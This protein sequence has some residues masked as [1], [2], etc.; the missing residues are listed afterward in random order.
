VKGILLNNNWELEAL[1]FSDVET[2]NKI[3]KTNVKGNRDPMLIR[4]PKEELKRVSRN[5]RRQY[6]ESDCPEIFRKL[7]FM[8]VYTNCQYFKEFVKAFDKLLES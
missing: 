6:R 8:E 4:E 5:E 7:R 1:I 3:Y 2:F